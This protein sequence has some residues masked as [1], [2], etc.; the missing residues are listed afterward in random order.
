MGCSVSISNIYHGGKRERASIRPMKRSAAWNRRRNA[1]SGYWARRDPLEMINP[2]HGSKHVEEGGGPLGGC[3]RRAQR[4]GVPNM[5]PKYPTRVDGVGR[6]LGWQ[7]TCSPL[8]RRGGRMK[9]SE[10]RGGVRVCDPL[11]GGTQDKVPG[12]GQGSG[13]DGAMQP[14]DWTLDIDTHSFAH[15]SITRVSKGWV[16][17]DFGVRTTAWR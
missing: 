14:R 4:P 16:L 1:D 6:T 11:L 10:R 2:T 5:G 13:R 15:H 12:R 8:G 7:T 17:S 9:E 3:R